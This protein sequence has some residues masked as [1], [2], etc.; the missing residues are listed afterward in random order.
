MD[1]A[2][3]VLVQEN[4]KSNTDTNTN[5][6]YNDKIE[7]MARKIYILEKRRLGSDFCDFCDREFKQ[8]CEKDRQEK[9]THIREMH[10]LECNVCELRHKNKEE[11][12]IHILTCEMYICSLCSYKHKRLSGKKN[13][14]KTKHT[15]NTIIKH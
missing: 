5:N 9:A 13:H 12:D 14:C 7:S 6:L 1:E 4:G 3:Y 8:G 2:P 11:L 15:Q 10:T